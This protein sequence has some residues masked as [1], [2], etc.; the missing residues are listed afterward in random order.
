VVNHP[1][2]VHEL[3]RNEN[4]RRL[5][6]LQIALGNGLLTSEGAW[7]RRQRQLARSVSMT[8]RHQGAFI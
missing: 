3:A 7:W 1:A 6:F 4:F 8:L 2:D 5:S